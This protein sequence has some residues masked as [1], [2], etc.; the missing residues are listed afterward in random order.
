MKHTSE[1]AAFYAALEESPADHVTKLALADWYDE[2]G[3]P[4][5]AEVLRY[6]AK[7]RKSPFRYYHTSEGLR[8]HH[9]TWKDGWYWWATSRER[10]GWGYPKAAVLPHKYWNRMKHTF[11]YD[12]L[13]F[14]EYRSVRAAIEA[15]IKS[16]PKADARR[17]PQK[18]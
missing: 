6:L 8:H 15:L 14:K 10:E 17:G 12:P 18:G 5:A 16:W 2:H 3:Q 7:R 13:V 4:V 11:P 9:E 1:L